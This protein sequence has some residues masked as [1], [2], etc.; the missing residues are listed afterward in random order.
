MGVLNRNHPTNPVR[1]CT[2]V[3]GGELGR[4][5]S[6]PTRTYFS[7]DV[8][9]L[10]TVK[11]ESIGSAPALLF[12]SLAVLAR[13]SGRRLD[14]VCFDFVHGFCNDF[15]QLSLLIKAPAGL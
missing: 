2:P 5:R 11:N 1:R 14:F 6:L 4:A 3:T 8:G 13:W 12:A 10:L 15:M 9:V 7:C